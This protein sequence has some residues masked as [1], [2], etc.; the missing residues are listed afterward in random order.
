[1][2]EFFH[3]LCHVHLLR[4]VSSRATL[5]EVS[6]VEKVHDINA[7]S[8]HLLY[9]RTT[10]SNLVHLTYTVTSGNYCHTSYTAESRILCT[11]LF[12]IN[13]VA[14]CFWQ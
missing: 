7:D 1:M 6:V 8:M 13:K 9:I 11:K 2:A 3:S 5:P 10:Q 12:I 4:N 14:L